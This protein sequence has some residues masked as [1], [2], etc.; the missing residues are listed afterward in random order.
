MMSVSINTP[1]GVKVLQASDEFR[2]TDGDGNESD[3]NFKN[4]EQVI[5]DMLEGDSWNDAASP[6][7]IEVWVRIPV[8][9]E[10]K[11]TVS[12]SL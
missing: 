4:L 3:C 9:I 7:E 11:K 8:R 10:V 5:L 2:V 6:E 1:C 12:V